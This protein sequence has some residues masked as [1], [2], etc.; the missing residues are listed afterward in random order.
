MTGSRISLD[1]RLPAEPYFIV[2]DRS[3]FNTS[4]V[5]RGINARDAM[6]GKGRLTIS[7]G[8]A[9]GMPAI[10]GHASVAGDFVAVNR[11]GHG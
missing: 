10:C 9:S 8:P 5:N 1:L 2:A 11:C 6:R 7:T 3:Q 4:V